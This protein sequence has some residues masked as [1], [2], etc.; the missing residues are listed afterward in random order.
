MLMSS[1]QAGATPDQIKLD[2]FWAAV[3]ADVAARLDEETRAA[4]C[5]ALLN[6][7]DYGRGADLRFSNRWFYL[8]ILAGREK[9]GLARRTWEKHFFPL[10]TRRNIGALIVLWSLGLLAAWGIVATAHAVLSR[11]LD[12]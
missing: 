8:R 5:D 7:E 3:P 1:P 10:L 4:L 12:A 6:Y 9:R 2:R 11:L